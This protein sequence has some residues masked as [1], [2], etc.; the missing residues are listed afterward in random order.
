[1]FILKIKNYRVLVNPLIAGVEMVIIFCLLHFIPSV[2]DLGLHFVD[3]LTISFLV[4]AG[5]LG[6]LFMHEYAH[7]LGALLMRLPIK[8]ITISVFG[9]YTSVDGQP[10]TP[11]EAFVVSNAGPL[12]N[13]F[14]GAIFYTGHI[15]FRQLDIAGTVCFCLAVFN[16]IFGAYNLLPVMPLDGGFIVRSAFWTASRDW[17]WSTRISFNIGTGVILVCL[18]TGIVNIF[19]HNPVT[20]VLFLIVGIGLWQT[21]RLA[22]QQMS[23]A[24]FLSMLNPK[25]H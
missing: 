11:K 8:G 24:R 22:Y 3:Y 1:M 9:A 23:A 7:V 19:I 4:F 12:K 17:G 16:G 13:I 20:G 18:A 21:E 2:A 10:S 14:M 6:S 25:H 15:A 5:S